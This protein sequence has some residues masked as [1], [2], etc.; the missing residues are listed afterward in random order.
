MFNDINKIQL[1]GN[2]TRDPELKTTAGGTAVLNLN[3]ATNRQYK[4]V[5][6]WVSEVE[7]HNVVI[8]GSTA[9]KLEQYLYKG[10]RVLIEGRAVTRTWEKDGVKHYKMEII[11]D[12]VHLLGRYVEKT[13]QAEPA[14]AS[15]LEL[16]I[17]DVVIDP[18]ELPF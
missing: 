8:F 12:E 13:K 1:L 7:Y 14:S 10:C 17:N 4:K 15:Q 18:D 6:E 9:T 5:E 11:S 2:L 3:L 16:N